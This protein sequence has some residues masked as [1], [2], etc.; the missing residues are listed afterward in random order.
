MDKV[1]ILGIVG[2]PR[3]KG[4]TAKLVA[5]ALEGAMSVPGIETELYE[6]AGKKMHHC[7]GC[8]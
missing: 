5:K 8:W 6:M 7:I 4:N 2:S 1:K 3:K